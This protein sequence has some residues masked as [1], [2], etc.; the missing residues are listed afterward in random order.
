MAV[1]PILTAY[2]SGHL[3][4]KN[5]G[6]GNVLFQLASTY[7]I[8]RKVNK[9]V[10]YHHLIDFGNKLISLYGL[11]HAD[12]IF[13]NFNKIIRTDKWIDYREPQPLCHSY[14]P[15]L[16]KICTENQFVRTHGYMECYDYFNDVSN[17]FIDLIRPD[18]ES[19]RHLR[20]T[21][22][23]LFDESINTV[24][25]HIRLNEYRKIYDIDYYIR[26]ISY[27]KSHI[28]NP[29]FLIF[30]DDPT[31]DFTPFG[32]S[33]YTIMTTKYDYMDMW[34]MSLCKNVICSYSTFCIWAC[35]LNKTPDA[36]ILGNKAEPFWK[37]CGISTIRPPRSILL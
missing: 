5:T 17:E 15:E 33:E 7:G 4:A 8:A 12:T 18:D 23:F 2:N 34:A 25:I 36:I 13:R 10:S 29:K 35:L 28:S 21:Y 9:E 1:A 37:L 3:S 24:A 26:A 30:T 16:I 14:I 31:T 6:L 22:P 19:T 20:D 32:L 11:N 27:M